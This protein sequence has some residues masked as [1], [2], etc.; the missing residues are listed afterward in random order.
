MNLY[1]ID[2]MSLSV[3][4][5]IA[6][7]GSISKGAEQANLAIGAA[8]RRLSELELSLGVLLFER[9]SRGVVLTPAGVALKK[10]SER[11][12]DEIRQLTS[13]ME[14]YSKGLKAVVRLWTNTAA[15]SQGLPAELAVFEAA[16]AIRVELQEQ[17]SR[18]IVLALLDGRADLGV[19]AEGTM[20]LG[21]QTT[22]YKE[23]RL[24]LAIPSTH[25]LTSAPTIRLT[26][27]VG[28]DFVS[29]PSETSLT[30]RL[31]SHFAELGVAVKIRFHVRSYEAMW[32]MVAAGMGLAILPR[33]AAQTFIRTTAVQIRDIEESW[34]QRR[35]LIAARGFDVLPRASVALL[36]HLK[37]S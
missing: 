35:L 4:C 21:L 20:L 15:L 6:R 33:A 5:F 7:A 22:S 25:P 2:L 27:T 23:D 13:D 36:E 34:A 24:V 32:H 26:D 14:D 18:A 3:F 31:A 1:R 37:R 28:F 30:Q 8:S 10:H 17:D 12:L 9:H 11:I 16:Q 19:V 29:L